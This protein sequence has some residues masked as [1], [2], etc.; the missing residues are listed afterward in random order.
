MSNA[1]IRMHFKA[2]D[3]DFINSAENEYNHISGNH[4]HMS[5]AYIQQSSNVT[6]V[7]MKT[8]YFLL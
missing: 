4:L 1:P 7:S 2:M 6:G 3:I 5:S 8:E